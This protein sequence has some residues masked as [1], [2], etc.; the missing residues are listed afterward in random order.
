MPSLQDKLFYVGGNSSLVHV[1][2]TLVLAQDADEAYKLAINP[3]R[4]KRDPRLLDGGIYIWGDGRD[5]LVAREI[6][7][8]RGYGIVK[9]E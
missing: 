1:P 2:F 9:E 4:G 6:N 5:S 3:P 7:L 8:P